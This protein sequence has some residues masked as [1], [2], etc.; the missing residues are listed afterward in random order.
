MIYYISTLRN[1]SNAGILI[2]E[3]KAIQ[4]AQD[5]LYES[6]KLDT[7]EFLRKHF[8]ALNIAEVG[9]V[10]VETVTISLTQF[11]ALVVEQNFET[12]YY[13]ETNTDMDEE[14]K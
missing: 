8:E 11:N 3:L 7:E 10:T 6:A 9:T 12:L 2:N 4:K 13:T 14:I 1:T 5:N